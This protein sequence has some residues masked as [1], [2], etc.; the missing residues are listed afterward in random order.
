MKHLIAGAL[1]ALLF[2]NVAQAA[3]VLLG[4]Y[5][6]E[7]WTAVVGTHKL[8]PNSGMSIDGATYGSGARNPV[9]LAV[10]NCDMKQGSL[11]IQYHPTREPQHF[12]WTQAAA[13]PGRPTLSENQLRDQ[14][15]TM[16]CALRKEVR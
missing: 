13:S 6:G 8:T 3:E 2:T 11:W 10:D 4:E 16:L 9:K 14:L 12:F 1:G 5:I 7:R 15:G